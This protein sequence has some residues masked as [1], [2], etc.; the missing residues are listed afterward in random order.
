MLMT[1]ILEN[2]THSYGDMQTLNALSLS[3]R[4]GEV[5]SLLGPSGCGKT[6]LLRVV[7]GLEHLSSGQIMLNNELLS[8][9]DHHPA[10]ENRPVGLVFQEHAL[11]PNMTVA[12]NIEFGLKSMPQADRQAR[13]KA[14]LEMVG[15]AG[16]DQRKPGTLSGGQQQRVAL[17]RALAPAPKVML[18]DEPYASVDIMLR[19]ELREAARVLLKEA[20]SA[21]ILVT[22]DPEEALEMSDKIAVMSKGRILQVDEPDKVI[23]EPVCAEVATLFGD[24]QSFDGH[25]EGDEFVCAAGRFGL[26]EVARRE[27]PV[28]TMVIRPSGVRFTAADDGEWIV[29]DLRYRSSGRVLFVSRVDA[30]AISLVRVDANENALPEI[31]AKGHLS[32]RQRN[33]FLFDKE[34]Q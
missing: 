30:A 2:L 12:E 17:A 6:T 29:R 28:N 13:R 9:P 24:A 10:P 26:G 14:L 23:N 5:V 25:V 15:L 8:A 7:A 16:Y 1:L 4:S 34:S 33:A 32:L 18:L 11:F 27:G 20:G 3:V 21:S 22:H 19:R 31:G